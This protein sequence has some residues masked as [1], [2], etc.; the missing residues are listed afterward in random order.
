MDP[1]THAWAECHIQADCGQACWRE[2]SLKDGGPGWAGVGSHVLDPT[3]CLFEELT[4][5]HLQRTAKAGG[6]T[7]PAR[8]LQGS[9]A[10]GGT[11]GL[12]CW[13]ARGW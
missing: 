7:V 5:S 9:H 10:S 2:L 6:L 4:G 11:L 12:V 3:P 13:R 8:C 1:K